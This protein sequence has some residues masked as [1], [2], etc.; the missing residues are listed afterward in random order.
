MLKKLIKMGV[1]MSLLVTSVS[2]FAQKNEYPSYSFGSNWAVGVAA[3][4]DWEMAQAAWNMNGNGFQDAWRASMNGGLDVFGKKKLNNEW[5]IRFRMHMPTMWKPNHV[6]K[7]GYYMTRYWTLTAEMMWSISN[8]VH[9]FDP[10]RRF[11]WYL[12]GGFGVAVC[13]FPINGRFFGI[14]FGEDQWDNTR[15]ILNGNG[16]VMP[17]VAFGLGYSYRF[18]EK[19]FVFAEAEL[20]VNDYHV[21]FWQDFANWSMTHADIRVGAMYD[22]GL[23]EADKAI[24]SQKNMLTQDNFGALNSQVASLEQQVANNRNNE[25]KL[26][27]RISELE[28]QLADALANQGNKVNCAAADSLQNIINQIKADQL[29]YYAMPFSVQY[30]VDEWQVSDEEMDKVKAVARVMKDNSN[31]KIKVVGF[32]DYTGTDAYNMKLSERRANE[33]KRLLTKKY[34]IAEDRIAVDFKGE[35]APFGD[36]QYAI[37][38]RVSFYRVIE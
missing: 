35:G 13:N 32:A 12:F 23:T 30:G 25:K 7:D 31:V 26:Q 16:Q 15:F 4:F 14:G 21:A 1:V 27:N 3:D 6:D 36:A 17:D 22:F 5:D 34:G 8:Y 18:A 2:A 10:E 33:V 29:N 19:W 11:S 24:A 20:N 9:G 28:K 37:N 38:R